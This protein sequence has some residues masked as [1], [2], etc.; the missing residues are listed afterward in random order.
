MTEQLS[1]NSY[2]SA[3]L[4]GEPI[5]KQLPKIRVAD[6]RRCDHV[7]TICVDCARTWEIDW[8]LNYERTA[9]GRRL[10]AVLDQ[11]VT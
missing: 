3:I 1:G 11:A 10:R 5:P 4:R 8:Q 7:E 9:A 6:E 2:V